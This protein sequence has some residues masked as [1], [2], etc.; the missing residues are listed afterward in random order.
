MA[1]RNSLKEQI[2]M[3]L[4]LLTVLLAGST[5]LMAQ[6]TDS[7]PPHVYNWSDLKINKEQNRTIRPVLEG[8]TTALSHFEVHSTT[9]EP[10]KAP[11]PPHVHEDMD[12]LIIVTEG[13]VQITIN[14]TSKMVEPGGIA[15]VMAGDKHSIE[16]T[17]EVSVT[18]YILKYKSKQ[19]MNT[20]RAKQQGGSFTVDWDSLEFKKTGKGGRRDFFNRPTSQLEKF[21]MHT[22]ALNPGFD[23]HAPH[24]HKEEEIILLLKGNVEMYIAGN[25][26]KAAPGDIIFLSSGVSHALKNTGSEQCEYFAFQWR[27]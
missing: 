24:T 2:S 23:S 8:S 27:N 21:E 20:E 26:Y 5:V 7:L 13:D 19:P 1:I 15:F 17:G 22:T 11:H 14:G 18:Y 16:N 12:E 9:L 3:K 4:I 25:L 6:Q 10:G